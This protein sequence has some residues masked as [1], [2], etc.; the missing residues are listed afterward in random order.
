[1]SFFEDITWPRDELANAIT[2]LTIQCGFAATNRPLPPSSTPNWLDEAARALGIEFEQGNVAE[3]EL[4]RALRDIGPGILQTQG[5]ILVISRSSTS[6]IEIVLPRDTRVCRYS[7]VLAALRERGGAVES[8]LELLRDVPDGANLLRKALAELD[9]ESAYAAVSITLRV[10]ATRAIS[11]ELASLQLRRR[12]LGIAASMVVTD[13]ASLGAT[14][15]LSDV[16]ISGRLDTARLSGWGLGI[17]VVAAIQGCLSYGLGR[18][19]IDL[20]ATVKRRLVEGTFRYDLDQARVE[21]YGT[22]LSRAAQAGMLDSLSIADPV[23]LLHGIA[24]AFVTLSLLASLQPSLVLVFG[25]TLLLFCGLLGARLLAASALFDD[26][27]ALSD[28]YVDRI[29]GHRTRVIQLPRALWHVGEDEPLHR[30]FRA[31]RKA[32]YLGL[33]AGMLP[34]LW[35]LAGM[36]FVLVQF[37]ADG[38]AEKVVLALAGVVTGQ[39]S[40]VA[41]SSAA[42]RVS[43]WYNALRKLSKFLQYA[44]APEPESSYFRNSAPLPDGETSLAASGLRFTYGSGSAPVLDGVSL[45]FAA[46]DRVLVTGPSGGGK[47]TLSAILTGLR[48]PTSGIVMLRGLDQHS[49]T[50]SAWRR[51]VVSVPQFQENHI[52]QDTL[53]FNLLMGGT[54]PAPPG[55]RVRAQRLCEE[56]GLGPLLDRMPSGLDQLLGDSGWQLS[57]GERSRIFMARALLQDADL[58]IFDESFGTLDPETLRIAMDVAKRHARTLMVIAHT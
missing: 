4:A 43:L 8:P 18:L 6:R 32:D 20:S 46:G 53:L 21:G 27:V 13:F 31:I 35:L 52:F 41:L 22:V 36:A 24:M 38:R 58:V 28:V 49:V 1:M 42:G 55:A 40:L 7:A 47:S 51:R 23:Q 11:D 17:L 16:A 48:K 5:R 45:S 37:V 33:A 14:L 57:H 44:E 19:N 54:W 25:T 34:R 15:L 29:L 9:G 2:A 56:L 30:Y 39:Q 26:Q 10:A 12:L 50:G 3:E